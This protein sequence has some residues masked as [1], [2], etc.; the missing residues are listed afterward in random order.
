LEG[1]VV[2]SYED[3]IVAFKD[4]IASIGKQLAE[5][6]ARRKSYSLAAATGDQKAIKAIQECDLLTGELTKQEQTISSAVETALALERQEAQEAEAAARRER[7]VE[8]H[9][10]SRGIIALNCELD[11]AL[12]RLRETFERRAHLLTELANTGVVD[13]GLVLR[14]A[15]KSGANASAQ[16][17]GLSK[18][19]ALEMTPN[20]AVRGLASA[21]EILLTIGEAPDKA[22]KPATRANAR[23]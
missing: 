19:L 13:S 6:G 7:E 23:H 5:L 11:E 17:A 3:R 10:I 1:V 22:D 18:F 4:Q 21:N 16:L 8:A 2:S 20:S 14:L 9:K 15:H 12:V